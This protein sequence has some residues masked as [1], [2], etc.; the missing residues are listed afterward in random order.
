[1]SVFTPQEI[2]YLQS[3][4]LARIA[5]VGSNNQPHVVPVSFRYNPSTDTIDI[6]GHGF[7]RRKKWRDV[8]QNP[9][10]AVVVDDIASLDPW[11]VRGIE[12]RGEA[13]RLMAG[14]EAVNPGFDAAMFRITPKRIAS[15]G[16]NPAAD[17]REPTGRSVDTSQ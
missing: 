15:W 16:I 12:I 1:M 5:T 17:A 9:R 2:D 3:Q 13:E 10:V 4:R 6:S 7:V 11:T 14:G 8:G